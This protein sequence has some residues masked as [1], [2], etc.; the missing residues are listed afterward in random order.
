[1]AN[2]IQTPNCEQIPD[3]GVVIKLDTSSVPTPTA[4]TKILDEIRN[5]LKEKDSN[6]IISIKSD[7]K[8]FWTSNSTNSADIPQI[9]EELVEFLNQKGHSEC[10]WMLTQ[11]KEL[12]WC[13]ADSCLEA[14]QMEHIQQLH[15][16]TCDLAAKLRMNGHTCV[17]LGQRMPADLGWCKSETCLNAN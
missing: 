4:P 9:V 17:S 15:K 6:K 8:I 2:Q 3:F 1:M 5:F 13:Q 11:P 10:T 7:Y 12:V 14:G 16:A